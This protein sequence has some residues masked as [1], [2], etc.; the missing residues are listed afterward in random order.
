MTTKTL[1]L[2]ECKGGVFVDLIRSFEVLDQI[3]PAY[4]ER[5]ALFQWKHRDGA[6]QNIFRPKNLP[7]GG[8]RHARW[9]FF[10]AM[11][12]RR[13][14]SKMVYQGHARVWEKYAG[15]LYDNQVWKLSATDIEKI[16]RENG[17]FGMAKTSSQVWIENSATLF[18]Q[19]DGDPRRLF[20]GRTVDDIMELKKKK[21]WNIPGFGPKI[22]SLLAMFYVEAGMI[23]QSFDAFPV[24]VHVQRISLSTGIVKI[25]KDTG[26][27]NMELALRPL[28]TS[29]CH[30]RGWNI[31]DAS[32]AL[33]LLGN[34]LCS[35]CSRT[36]ASKLYC[37][38]YDLCGGPFESKRYFTEGKW[39]PYLQSPPGDRRTWS[40]PKI[41]DGL[42][43]TL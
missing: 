13:E 31:V 5:K 3:V 34:S 24:D 30:E 7:V 18:K 36:S 33:W 37:P 23:E 16:L 1:S 39:D 10:A 26:N 38:A 32:H 8:V 28:L 22:V 41:E 12:D 11:T 21:K 17:G 42:F 4:L 15:L 14:E 6:P 20:E 25:K 2:F 19:F 27:V 9:L 29:I 43:S 35:N 40:L